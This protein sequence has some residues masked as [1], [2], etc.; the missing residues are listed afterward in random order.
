MQWIGNE[1][2]SINDTY[3][4]VCNQLAEGVN[5]V[6][7]ARHDLAVLVGV[8]VADGQLL[9]MAEHADTH[10]LLNALG[11]GNHQIVLQEVGQ[12][13]YQVD[14]AHHAQEADQR[15]V[16]RGF[17]LEQRLDIIVHQCAQ[18]TGAEA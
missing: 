17:L 15:S 5:V 6:R 2:D 11:Y 18:R 10:I 7:I 3:T 8:K 14:A 13:T 12:G 9:H 1:T 16:V 4:R